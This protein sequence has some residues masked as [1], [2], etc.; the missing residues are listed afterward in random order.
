MAWAGVRYNS[1]RLRRCY[2]HPATLKTESPEARNPACVFDFA[3]DPH[4][5][6]S[7]LLKPGPVQQTR[8][9]EV[10]AVYDLSNCDG[11]FDDPRWR[12]GILRHL[13]SFCRIPQYAAPQRNAPHPLW[14]WVTLKVIIS[15]W[16]PTR[17]HVSNSTSYKMH[18]KLSTT[19]GSDVWFY[20]RY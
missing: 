10:Q 2:P 20:Y 13:A 7:F 3:P 19:T 17:I 6:Y 18:T 16:N 1:C 9:L 12:C 15:Y 4:L 8:Q 11:S 5:L 14:P